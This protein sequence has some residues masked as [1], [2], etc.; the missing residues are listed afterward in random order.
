MAGANNKIAIVE[1]TLFHVSFWRVGVGG[2]ASVGISGVG[3]VFSGVGA[4]IYVSDI[5]I[6][7]TPKA[8]GLH[9]FTPAL[10]AGILGA[11][12]WIILNSHPSA[13]GVE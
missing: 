3:G 8:G 12:L 9:L 10:Q 7:Y 11:T 2:D 5:S 6:K 1:I 13:G 4:G